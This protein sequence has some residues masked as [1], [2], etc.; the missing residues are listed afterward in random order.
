MV[1]LLNV[2]AKQNIDNS[3]VELLSENVGENV[4]T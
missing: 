3:I 2:E 1:A 4:E